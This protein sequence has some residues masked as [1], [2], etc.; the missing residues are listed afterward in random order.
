MRCRTCLL[1]LH[2]VVVIMAAYCS[3]GNEVEI[4]GVN[5]PE[6]SNQIPQFVVYINDENRTAV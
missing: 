3:G 6:V 4:R 5:L 2:I 1:W